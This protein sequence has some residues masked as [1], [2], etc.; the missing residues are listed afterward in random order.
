MGDEQRIGYEELLVAARESFETGTD[1]TVAVEE[2]FALLDPA[3]L[4][5][6][7]RFEEVQAAAQGTSLRAEPRRRADRL[8][9]RGQDRALRDVRRR[10]GARMAERRAQLQALV[11]PLGIALGATG[12][13]PW[14]PLAGA[15]DH[16]HAALPPQRRAAP[17]R[18][19]AQQHLRPPRP[20]RHPRRRSRHRGRERA[21]QPAARAARALGELAVRRERQL[22]PALGA[23]PDL[24]ALLPALRRPGRVRRRGS[25]TRTTSASSTR[26]ARSPSTRSSGGACARTSRFRRS[27]SASATG[28]RTSRRRRRWPRSPPRSPRGSPAPTTRA[29]RSPTSRTG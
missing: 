4:G 27:R 5:L 13:H 1:F 14:A 3:T 26:P 2:E 15:A 25:S 16:R 18:R 22:R 19:L 12:T 17:L 23:H 10:S 24:H 21:P 8:R 9:G 11:D 7:N 29:S 20:R 6:V 28:S